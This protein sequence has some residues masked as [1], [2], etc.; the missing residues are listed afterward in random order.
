MSYDDLMAQ[1]GVRR[2]GEREKAPA[3]KPARAPAPAAPS[4]A[5]SRPAGAP[6]APPP[7]AAV[8]P[9]PGPVAAPPRAPAAVR[10]SG[11]PP[12]PEASPA[13]LRAR[14][15]LHAAQAAAS[16]LAARVDA[17][18]S[19][20]DSLR[21]ERD[22]LQSE[23]DSLR[24]EL[25]SLRSERDALHAE[26]ATLDAERRSLQRRLDAAPAEGPTLTFGAALR[27]RGLLGGAEVSRALAALD[28]RALLPALLAQVVAS[29]PVALARALDDALVLVCD[30]CAAGASTR[31]A[32]VGVPAARCEVCDGSDAGRAARRFL[33]ACLMLGITRVL[34]VGGSPKSH[35]HLRSFFARESRVAVRL[36][37]GDTKIAAADARA[38]LRSHGL[39]VIWGSTILDHAV[40]GQFDD[41]ETH[42]CRRVAVAVR[43]AGR[44]LDE[45]AAA[46]GRDPG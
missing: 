21:S 2:L 32:A 11:P 19:E 39:V 9:P 45:A 17:L 15:E 34:L 31:V 46:L 3:P 14:D 23:R 13:L 24:S 38:L 6:P 4:P 10:P 28:Q 26:R 37:P 43:G 35:A 8:P 16:A 27:A 33:D 12:A 7:R 5:A 41:A 36:Q 30:N 20:R 42:G 18:Q 1:M 29:D 25:D 22:S 44:M 40:S